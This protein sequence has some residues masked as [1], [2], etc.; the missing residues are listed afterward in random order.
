MEQQEQLFN[1]EGKNGAVQ[2]LSAGDIR[3]LVVGR[4]IAQGAPL[5]QRTFIPRAFRLFPA[6]FEACEQLRSTENDLAAEYAGWT[7]KL[8]EAAQ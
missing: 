2:R 1:F 5:P 3:G 4:R 8:E 6:D 7:D